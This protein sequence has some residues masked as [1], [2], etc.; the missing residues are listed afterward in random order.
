MKKQDGNELAKI[1]NCVEFYQRVD[2]YW[3]S[4][5]IYTL[6]LIVYALFQSSIAQSLITVRADDPI[7]IILSII[8]ITSFFIALYANLTKSTIQ[9]YPDKL[10][11]VN[12]FTTIEIP[13]SSIRLMKFQ[14]RKLGLTQRTFG[15]VKIWIKSRNR[16]ISI[17]PALFTKEELLWDLFHDLNEISEQSNGE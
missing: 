1:N 15:V 14:E 10:T 3:Q 9:V 4:F 13:F 16:P 2:F 8:A 12:K 6:A 17:K 11:V 7:I 5:S